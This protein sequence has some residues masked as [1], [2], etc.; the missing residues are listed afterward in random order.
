MDYVLPLTSGFT[1]LLI[2]GVIIGLS[3]T[4]PKV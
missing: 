1:V 2:C 3:V 4:H